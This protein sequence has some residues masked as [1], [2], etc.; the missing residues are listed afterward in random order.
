[1]P[2][3][4]KGIIFLSN[5]LRHQS[6]E[7]QA[8]IIAHE[9]AHFKLKHKLAMFTSL[10]DEEIEKQESEANQL[11][12]VWLDLDLSKVAEEKTNG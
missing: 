12:A 9:I 3:N 1:M 10:T 5:C 6:E 4:F 8:L 7:M 11:A 2:K